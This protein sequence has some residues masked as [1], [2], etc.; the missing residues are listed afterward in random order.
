VLFRS[1]GF[2]GWAGGA[3]DP[4]IGTYYEIFEDVELERVLV[5]IVA[6]DAQSAAEYVGNSLFCSLYKLNAGSGELQ[7]EAISITHEIQSNEFGRLVALQFEEP[8]S[9]QAGDLIAPIAGFFSGAD[10][11]IAFAGKTIA[12]SVVGLADGGLIGLA[13][14]D[15]GVTV[16]APVVRLDFGTY[17]NIDESALTAS[18]VNLYPNPAS[19]NATISFSLANESTVSVEVRDLAGKLI[20]SSNEGQLAAGS[21]ELNLSTAAMAEGM[22]TY[23][24]TSGDA[25][26]TKKFVVK[27]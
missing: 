20:Y 15:N 26:I 27:K 6:L 11:P 23:T 9:L 21:H 18:E 25:Q 5:G 24:L 3:A 2:F 8:I 13:P 12:G 17:L 7:F 1:G 10:V 14:D 19:N 4:G 16:D 22:Y